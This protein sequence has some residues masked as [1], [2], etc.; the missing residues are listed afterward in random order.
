MAKKSIK[1]SWKKK[2]KPTSLTTPKT[3]TSTKAGSE[4]Q[5]NVK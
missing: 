1:N 5:K 4:L 3:T 2:A